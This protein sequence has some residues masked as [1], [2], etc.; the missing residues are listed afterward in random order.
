M[1]AR[2]T[3][4]LRR[5]VGAVASDKELVNQINSLFFNGSHFRNRAVVVSKGVHTLY[6]NMKSI[7]PE[8]K[9]N[10]MVSEGMQATLRN[11]ADTG[12]FKNPKNTQ[13]LINQART[14]VAMA[15][16]YVAI[17]NYKNRGTNDRRN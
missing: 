7:Y 5:I 14:Y 9:N 1:N 13:D 8:L 3:K 15:G 10:K 11:F 4:A 17:K 16:N 2:K 6:K 12:V